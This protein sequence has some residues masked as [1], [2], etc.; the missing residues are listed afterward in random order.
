MSMSH[1]RNPIRFVGAVLVPIA[2]LATEISAQSR[3]A[4]ERHLSD[5]IAE[6]LRSPFHDGNAAVVPGSEG[7]LLP[8][9]AYP[10]GS[11]GRR[12]FATSWSTGHPDAGPVPAE[13]ASPPNRP[14]GLTVFTAIGSHIATAVFLRCQSYDVGRYTGPGRP[15]VIGSPPGAG[16]SLCGPLQT[17]RDWVEDGF[18]LLVPT[19]T[20]AGAATLSGRGFVESVGGSALSYLGSLLFYK[21]MTEVVDARS[22]HDLA[23]PVWFLGGLM[24]GIATAYLSG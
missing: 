15:V 2:A 11:Q 22:I 21:G 10:S 1:P 3:S 7:L 6:V 16:G 18:L 24:H 14:F 12:D 19:L 23:I 9:V 5:A 13:V 20:T 4:S 17:S 8:A